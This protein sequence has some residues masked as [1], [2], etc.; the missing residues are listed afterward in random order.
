[1]LQNG[2]HSLKLFVIDETIEELLV[3]EQERLVIASLYQAVESQPLSLHLASGQELDE[4]P[5]QFLNIRNHFESTRMPEKLQKGAQR[6]ETL[7]TMLSHLL[8]FDLIG[9]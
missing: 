9:L 1:M 4:N 8:G 5:L 2:Y 7:V 6:S 3:L